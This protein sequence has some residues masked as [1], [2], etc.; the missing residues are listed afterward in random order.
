MCTELLLRRAWFPGDSDLD[1]L[2]KIFQALGT[3]TE[4]N[5]PGCTSLPQYVDFNPTPAQPLRTIF[6]QVCTT[7]A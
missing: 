5:W 6:R 3:P 1:Q 7:S 4:A 2:G